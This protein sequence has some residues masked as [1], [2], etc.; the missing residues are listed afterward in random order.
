[1]FAPGE[2]VSVSGISKGKGFQG[3]VKGMDLKGAQKP[4]DNQIG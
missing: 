2:L 1:M 4:T 3:V